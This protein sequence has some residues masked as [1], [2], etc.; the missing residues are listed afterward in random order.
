MTRLQKCLSLS[1]F[2]QSLITKLLLTWKYEGY[3]KWVQS[4]SLL[5]HLVIVDHSLLFIEL[6][7]KYKAKRDFFL[8]CLADEF[9]FQILSAEEDITWAGS[10]IYLVSEKLSLRDGAQT[11]EN[12][13]VK[14]RTLFSFVPPSRF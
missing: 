4:L 10:N 11:I 1:Y 2:L 8:D 3:V 5:R 14:R 6:S 9:N 7:Q 12:V 13:P